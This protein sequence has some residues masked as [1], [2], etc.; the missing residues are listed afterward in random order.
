M[1]RPFLAATTA[2]TLAA[3]IIAPATA[4]AG[5]FL[6]QNRTVFDEPQCPSTTETDNEFLGKKQ[7][8]F[9]NCKTEET[10]P[11]KPGK[12]SKDEKKDSDKEKAEKDESTESPK[13][14]TDSTAS[15]D[16]KPEKKSPLGDIDKEKL[17]EQVQSSAEGY[18]TVQ[19][20]IK[21]VLKV[22]H[23]VRKIFIP[24]P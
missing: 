7:S 6:D 10:K 18:K 1:K 11:T 15:E 19:P 8:V 22:L 4:S 3:G 9:D 5:E 2:L 20:I 24:F 17:K 16:K 13:E 12:D 14:D 21:G 23:I